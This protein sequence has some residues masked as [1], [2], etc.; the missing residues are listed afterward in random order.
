MCSFMDRLQPEPVPAVSTRDEA[1]LVASV[2]EAL[3]RALDTGE[4]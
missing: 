4:D 3:T 1:F 2:A